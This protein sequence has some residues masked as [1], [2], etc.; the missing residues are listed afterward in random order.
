MFIVVAVLF[1]WK[2]L[3]LYFEMLSTVLYIQMSTLILVI[4][5]VGLAWVKL[6]MS[7]PNFFTQLF[8]EEYI[9]PQ[10]IIDTTDKTGGS[11]ENDWEYQYD[12]NDQDDLYNLNDLDDLGSQDEQD[13][14]DDL[15]DLEGLG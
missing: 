3:G 15:G 8:S 12:H 2:N 1:L 5:S 6:L 7:V 10:E 14:L 4:L 13:D 9:I 11:G